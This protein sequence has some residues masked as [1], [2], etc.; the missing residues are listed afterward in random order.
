[1]SISSELFQIR[2]FKYYIIA[3]TCFTFGINMLGTVVAWQVYEITKDAY[4]LGLIGLFEFIP[5]LLLSLFGGYMA[6]IFDRKKIMQTCLFAY[7]L[8]ALS[9]L[10]LSTNTNSL[11]S[12][13][14]VMPIYT[15]IF[16]TGLIRGFLG[17]AQN[18]FMSQLI[19]EKLY[20]HSAT[21]NAMSYQIG[22]VGG[23]AI[24][25]LLYYYYNGANIPYLV[26][27]ILALIALLLILTIKSYHSPIAKKRE[28][29]FISIREG[30]TYVTSNQILFGSLTLDMFAVL[31]GGAVAMIPAFTDKILGGGALANGILRTA[32]AVGS[33]VMA[34]IMTYYPPKKNAGKLFLMA[35]AAFGIC[36]ILFGISQNYTLSYILLAGTGFFDNISMV[37][38]GTIMQLYVPNEMRGRV[39]AVSGIFIGSSNELG[40]FESGLAARIMGLSTSVV[41]GG[42]MTLL[43]VGVTGWRAPKL[44]DLEL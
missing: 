2:D 41:F 25:G 8:C 12:N 10:L 17:P 13:Y 6:D 9:L 27:F 28:N 37:V 1:M 38:R 11:F 4:S 42:I 31:F 40:S 23:P 3:R 33:L 21:Y 44:R 16:F 36:T 14:G 24:G 32:P 5:Y 43:T 15:V 29:I 34:V 22:A 39:N 30:L 20:A 18:S 19:P 35:V 26:V 7:S